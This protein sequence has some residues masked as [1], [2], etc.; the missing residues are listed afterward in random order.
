[1]NHDHYQLSDHQ[2]KSQFGDC[3]LNP[4]LF[5]HEAHLRLAWIHIREHGEEQAV[6]NICQQIQKFDST[7]GDG[8][9]YHK[10]VTI[11]A[12]KIVHHFMKKSNADSFKELISSFPRLRDNFKELLGAHYSF[13]IF[14]FNKASIEYIEPDI[15]SFDQ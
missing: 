13:D 7:H 10:T 12:I 14:S 9:K 4:S 2:F 11:A 8:T 5:T 1:M 6:R 3:T 15:Q